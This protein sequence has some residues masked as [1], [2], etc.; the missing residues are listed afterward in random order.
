[1]AYA[2]WLARE[3]GRPYRLPSEAEWEYAARAGRSTDELRHLVEDNHVTVGGLIFL[4]KD[5]LIETPRP[6]D[7]D[8]RNPFGLR[9]LNTYAQSGWYVAEWTADCWY[10]DYGGTPTTGEPRTDGDCRTGVTRGHIY[11]PFVGRNWT[12]LVHDGDISEPTLGFRV[13]RSPM[14]GPLVRP[15]E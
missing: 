15:G 3:T 1:M 9:G 11:R 6:V 14:S 2:E 5:V 4:Q 12:R 8:S 13:V 10:P 7:A